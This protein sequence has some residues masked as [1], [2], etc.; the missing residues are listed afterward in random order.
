MIIST[1]AKQMA[2]MNTF[3]NGTHPASSTQVTA[4]VTFISLLKLEDSIKLI[5]PIHISML[6]CFTLYL[7]RPQMATMNTFFNGTHPARSTQVTAQVTFVS[8]L[9]R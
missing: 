7:V 5:L 9:K 2:T 6:N 8:F 1:K 3:S 4:Q